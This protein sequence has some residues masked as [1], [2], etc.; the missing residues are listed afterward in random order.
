MSLRSLTFSGTALS[1]TAGGLGMPTFLAVSADARCVSTS[2][3]PTS[4][5]AVKVLAEGHILGRRSVHIGQSP[6]NDWGGTSGGVGVHGG[7]RV[8]EL[9]RQAFTGS[10]QIK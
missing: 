4:K 3:S 7:F 6:S 10:K 5:P 8:S 1:K 9:P 2:A